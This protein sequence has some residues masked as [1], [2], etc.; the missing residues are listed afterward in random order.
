M[1][2]CFGASLFLALLAGGFL[3]YRAALAVSG[4]FRA[5][6]SSRF[7]AAPPTD[8]IADLLANAGVV[9]TRWDFLLAAAVERG[10]RAA[11]RR[12]SLRPT[13][14]A[15]RSLRPH[16]ARRRLL[17]ELVVPEGKNMFD[18][19]HDRRA[20]RTVSGGEVSGGGARPVDDPRPRSAGARRWRATCSR[21]RT[22]SAATP[23]RSGCAT[24]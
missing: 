12:V 18:I 16:R 13:G 10:R 6:C 1:K 17:F 2:F 19:A 8:G 15:H 23:R 22:R 7:R 4:L 24:R 20:A 14:V 5:R 3:I 21:T 9:R 11:G